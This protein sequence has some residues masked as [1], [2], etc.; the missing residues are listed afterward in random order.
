MTQ[1]F[2]VVRYEFNMSVRRPGLWISFGILCLF[3]LLGLNTTSGD[4][5]MP[6]F[7]GRGMFL[8]AAEI[9]F[10]FHMI[11]PLLA[12]ILASDRLQRDYRFNIREL[13]ISTPTGIWKFLLAKYLGVWLSIFLAGLVSTLVHGIFSILILNGSPLFLLAELG[14]FIV[15][16]GPAYAFVIAFSLGCPL[17]MPVRVYQILFTGYWVWGNL[18]SSRL[19]P[20]ISN[21]LL[22]ASGMYALQGFF[23]S[24]LSP[25]GAVPHSSTEAWLNILVIGLCS[26]AALIATGYYA[27]WQ[28]KQA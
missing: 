13:Q 9:V 10:T 21:T 22:N 3:F 12:G 8:E 23:K 11:S 15:M 18:L 7:S 19:I 4:G 17:I 14:A 6:H 5:L 26:A 25:V 20:S 2:N 16:I 27:N 1:F 28:K 24:T